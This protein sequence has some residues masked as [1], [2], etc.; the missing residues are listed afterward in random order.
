MD[1]DPDENR[2]QTLPPLSSSNTVILPEAS[3]GTYGLTYDVIFRLA[4][5]V[6]NVIIEPS[7]GDAVSPSFDDL[8]TLQRNSVNSLVLITDFHPGEVTANIN[9]VDDHLM[10]GAIEVA[11]MTSPEPDPH[12]NTLPAALERHRADDEDALV[13]VWNRP[14]APAPINVVPP[15]DRPRRETSHDSL[16]DDNDEESHD[17]NESEN[18]VESGY[19]AD[20]ESS[21]HVPIPYNDHHT[22]VAHR[23]HPD[24]SGSDASL[25][26]RILESNERIITRRNTLRHHRTAI[27]DAEMVEPGEN[28]LRI[29]SPHRRLQS[30]PCGLDTEGHPT[31]GTTRPAP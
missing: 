17:D 24:A 13:F 8:R 30:A 21:E 29:M 15:F 7:I 22:H 6:D 28:E 16:A 18:D 12:G 11:R 23:G 26:Q 3:I 2:D 14:T 5:V 31:A 4:Q 27:S 1:D 19:L 9:P 20:Q 25:T 10:Y